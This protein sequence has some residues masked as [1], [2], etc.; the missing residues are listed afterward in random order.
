[1]RTKRPLRAN[2]KERMEAGVVI[3][4]YKTRPA[5]VRVTGERTFAITLTEGKRHQIRRMV[6][7]LFNEVEDLKRLRVMN[8]K[9]GNLP[10][11]AYRSIEGE[12]LKDFLMSLSL[13]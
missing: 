6:V 7:A 5:K 11:G 3:E 10:G 2:F 8:V 12:E 4:G 1:M 13:Y 9:L